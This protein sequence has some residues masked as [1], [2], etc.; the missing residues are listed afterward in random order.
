V[1]QL[2]YS[3]RLVLRSLRRDPGYTSVM[4]V[5]LTLSV[6]LFVTA[7]AA[8]RRFSGSALVRVPGVARV[9]PRWNSTEP[10]YE[11]TE[12]GYFSRFIDFFVSAPTARALSGTGIPAAEATSF[13]GQVAGG[14]P[15]APAELL[16]VRFCGRDLFTMFALGFRWGGPF[17]GG[18]DQA[19]LNDRLNNR[20]FGGANSV[21]RTVVLEGR[22]LTVVGVLRPSPTVFRVWDWNPL[23][24]PGEM[25][26]PAALTETL[27]PMVAMTYPPSHPPSWGAVSASPSYAFI[28]DWVALPD[29][30]SRARF[31]AVMRRVDPRLELVFADELIERFFT[32]PPQYTIFVI[33]AGVLVLGNVLNV[34]RLLLAKGSARAAEL[35]IH[36]ALGAPRQ[37][38]FGRQL[39]E[40]VVVVL[41]G[42]L[43]GVLLGVPTI[44]LF[45]RLV[46]D[47]STPLVLDAR[48]ALLTLSLCLLLSVLAGIYPAWRVAAVP[49][50]R[51]LGRV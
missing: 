9:Q 7:A 45:D 37:V 19:V 17:S 26:V 35:G 49:P 8:Y 2:L 50:T 23:Q 6:S 42:S 30:A 12:F 48:T 28:E 5:S 1:S 27:R 32:N 11:H 13:I 15:G 20:L 38:L 3:L 25:L 21:G 39:L 44:R 34:V 14:L 10:F 41:G 47:L 24:D 16:G 4:I 18:G 51:Y 40:G 36:R 43:T 33:F 22:P 31:E 29:A 46:P